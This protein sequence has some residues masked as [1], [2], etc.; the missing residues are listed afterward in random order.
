MSYYRYE[1]ISGVTVVCNCSQ[2]VT[3]FLIE[4]FATGF[5]AFSKGNFEL[6][7]G[8]ESP[9]YWNNDFDFIYFQAE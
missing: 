3:Y 4:E 1:N 9:T 8:F 7:F 2:L 5:V 6:I